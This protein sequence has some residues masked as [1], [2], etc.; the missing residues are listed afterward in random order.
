MRS[1]RTGPV[2]VRQCNLKFQINSKRLQPIR[3]P[4]P[5][6]E[7]MGRERFGFLNPLDIY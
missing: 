3:W 5:C 4:E 1:H 2:V 7:T 6:P